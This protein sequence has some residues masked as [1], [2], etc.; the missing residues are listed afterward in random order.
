MGRRDAMV[1]K[2]GYLSTVRVRVSIGHVGG[3]VTVV[4]VINR[5]RSAALLLHV[6]V[7]CVWWWYRVEVVGGVVC[8]GG[9]AG[10]WGAVG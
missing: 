5:G 1:C 10:A 6:R 3:H 7:V 4:L 2:G 8:S 9:L